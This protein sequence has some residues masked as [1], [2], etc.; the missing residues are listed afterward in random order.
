MY[1][2][3]ARPLGSTEPTAVAVVAPTAC[4]A[5]VTAT[6]GSAVLKLRSPPKVVPDAFVATRR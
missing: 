3:V 5:P 6:G 1:H 2:V 4:A